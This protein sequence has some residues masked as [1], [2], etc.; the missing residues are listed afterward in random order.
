MESEK[1]IPERRNILL[2]V[3][4]SVAAVLAGKT[5]EALKVFGE[6]QVVFT[7]SGRY[8]IDHNDRATAQFEG[9]KLCNGGLKVWGD[10]DEWPE[11]YEK[12]DDVLHI[13]LRKWA[14]VLVIAPLSANTLA[15][16]TYGICDNLLTSV[17]RAWDNQ[18]PVVVAPAMNTCMW[19]NDLTRHQIAELMIRRWHVVN[20]VEKTLACGDTGVGAMAPVEE[21]VA[22]TKHSLIYSGVS[23]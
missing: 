13:E 4:G 16:V 21:I 17:V 10:T 23:L 9:A 8:F 18:K 15:K 11:K 3:T 2:G 12:D 22:E 7:E 19:D 20:P 1:R 5:A 6:V 14:D